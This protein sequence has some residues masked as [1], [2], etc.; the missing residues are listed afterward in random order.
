M[1]PTARSLVKIAEIENNGDRL[2][3]STEQL[4]N[5]LH[6]DTI[7]NTFI[8]IQEKKIKASVRERRANKSNLKG[9]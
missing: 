3:P 7:Q 2:S 1:H 4:R 5:R 6:R 9:C 8:L